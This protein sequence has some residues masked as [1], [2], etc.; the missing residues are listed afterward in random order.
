MALSE[1]VQQ[2]LDQEGVT[3]DSAREF[4]EELQTKGAIKEGVSFDDPVVKEA[5][6]LYLLKDSLTEGARLAQLDEVGL[7]SL[8]IRRQFFEMTGA[9]DTFKELF[10]KD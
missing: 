3:E 5:T 7:N 1:G 4:F 6:T 9:G 8:E 2:K 10:K